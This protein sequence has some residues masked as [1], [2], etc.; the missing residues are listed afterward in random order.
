MPSLS[1]EHLGSTVKPSRIRFPTSPGVSNGCKI[2]HLLHEDHR[3]KTLQTSEG[4]G[5]SCRINT[6]PRRLVSIANPDGSP[7]GQVTAFRAENVHEIP[8][9]SG[10]ESVFA[11]LRPDAVPLAQTIPCDTSRDGLRSLLF[12]PHR[13]SFSSSVTH[14]MKPEKVFTGGRRTKAEGEKKIETREELENGKR[15]QIGNYT[16]RRQKRTRRRSHTV[17]IRTTQSQ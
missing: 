8:M 14:V 11:R 16:K 4:F 6:E 15:M 7:R 12:P 13:Q 9:K 17:P 3:L 1:P 5:K 10:S 2:P